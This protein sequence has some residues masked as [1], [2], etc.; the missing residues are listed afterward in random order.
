MYTKQVRWKTRSL[1]IAYSLYSSSIIFVP[2]TTRIG[3]V[4]PN[5]SCR[6]VVVIFWA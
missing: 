4:L 2:K 3:H 5:Y 1:L 6:L